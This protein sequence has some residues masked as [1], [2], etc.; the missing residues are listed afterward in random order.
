MQGAFESRFTTGT[1]ATT[2]RPSINSASSAN[3][4]DTTATLN[5]TVTPNGA[6]TSVHFEYGTTTS[7]GSTTASQSIGSGNSPVSVSANLTGLSAGTLY[8][9]RAVATNSVGSTFGNTLTFTT[10]TPLPTVVSTPASFIGAYGANVNGDVTPNGLSTSVYFEWGDRS[11]SLSNSNS[12][13]SIGAGTTLVPN[14]AR[15]EG[16]NPDSTYFF[17]IVAVNTNSSSTNK[18]Y[19]ATLSFKTLPVKPTVT[20]LVVTNTTATATTLQGTVNPN[21]SPTSFYFEY[22]ATPSY[23]SATPAQDA[24]SGSNSV[25]LTAA[26]TGLT[27]GQTYYY[28]AVSSNSFG[29]SYGTDQSF[30]TGNPPPSAITLAPGSLTT[31]SAQLR[32]SVNPNSS[33]ASSWFEWGTSTN[34]GSSSQIISTDLGESYATT[35]GFTVSGNRN[36]GTGFSNFLAYTLNNGGTFIASGSATQTLDGVKSFGIY[37][38]TSGAGASLRRGIT[39]N[40]VRQ[41]GRLTLSTKFLFTNLV[42]FA[43]FNIK[44][45]AGNSFGASELLRFGMDPVAGSQILYLIA[46][47]NRQSLDF[48]ESIANR[49]LDIILDF[50]SLNGRYALSAKFRDQS[51]VRKIIGSLGTNGAAVNVTHIGFANFNI[52]DRQDLMFD[53]L[54]VRGS[55]PMGAGSNSVTVSNAL[56]GLSSNTLYNYRVAAMNLDG[57]T[58]TG[59]NTTFFTGPDLAITS[60][61]TNA[62]WIRGAAG[63]ITLTISNAGSASSTTNPLTVTATLPAGLTSTGMA[64]TGWTTN[65]NGLSCT[66]S[67]TL[68]VGSNHPVITLN[69]AVATNAPA[70]LQPTFTLSGG[71]DAFSS[72]NTV[73][74]TVTTISPADSWRTQFFGT[75]NNSGP[76]ADTS[77]YAGDGIA[78]LV[79]YALGMNPTVPATN[80]LPEM[81][82]TNNKLSLTFN[83]QKSATDIVYE[84]QAAGDLFGFSNATVLWSSASNAYGGG[85]NSSQ[86]VTVEDTAS[87][88]TTNRRFMRLQISRP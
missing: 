82:V 13:V 30:S 14:F 55:A 32:G 61:V 53:S 38:G 76:T 24:G 25:S 36:F 52:G 64:G 12:P 41:F 26:L 75:T 35:S 62:P 70:T 84:V 17:R 66:R 69:V 28:R 43:G 19:G 11:D 39:N 46:G 54:E 77:S 22:G 7:F 45:A 65:S 47:T 73:T 68:A 37:P 8:Y 51:S 4:A 18:T 79:K 85:T 88:A 10:T 48:G 72:N 50:D 58:N 40:N 86:T 67:N 44:S 33:Y 27:S 80:G 23:G 16:L 56:S 81:K 9:Y 29:V 3:L 21:G 60:S 83:R 2:A 20:T 31:T 5:A 34:Y 6:A 63:Q 15:A 78:N 71:G 74:S 57:G 49:T 59:V 42:G 87:T 1:N